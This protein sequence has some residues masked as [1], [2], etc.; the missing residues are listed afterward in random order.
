M[1]SCLVWP[2]TMEKGGRGSGEVA[3]MVTKCR[4]LPWGL[5]TKERTGTFRLLSEILEASE[6]TCWLLSHKKV[7]VNH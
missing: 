5:P 4:E 2:K 1:L 7:E 3:Q 6:G